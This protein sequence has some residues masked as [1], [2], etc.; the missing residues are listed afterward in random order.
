M[1]FLADYNDDV[2]SVTFKN[3]PK[4]LKLTTP[5]IQK[6]IIN[7]AA[8]E[9]IDKIMI[10]IGDALFSILVDESCD[11]SMKEQMAIVFY[12]VDK[13]WLRS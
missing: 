11:I 6:D 3:A 1:K 10:D 9:I 13:K 4:S 12:F 5:S 2:K 7:A 8:V